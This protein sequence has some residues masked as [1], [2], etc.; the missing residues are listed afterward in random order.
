MTRRDSWVFREG[1]QVMGRLRRGRATLAVG[2]A[3]CA[4]AALPGQAAGAG[5]P[6]P[7]AFADQAV[8]V[9]GATDSTHSVKLSP[10]ST[11]KSSI[12]RGGKLYYQLQLDARETVYVSATVVPGL[13][14]K[15]AY[16]DGVEVSLQDTNGNDCNSSDARFG[17]SQSPRPITAWA[18]RA[19]GPTENRCKAAGTYY[20]VVERNSDPASSTE[21]WDTELRVVS[22][23]AVAKNAPTTPPGSWN[24]AS[25]TPP[26][27]ERK[28]RRGG[29]GFND[30][31]ALRAGTWGDRIKPGQTLFYRVPVDW[32]QQISAGAELGSASGGQ[33]EYVTSAL[34]MSL[35]NPVRGRVDDA[36]T[37]YDGKQKSTALEPLAPV[38][39]ENRFSPVDGVAG[40]RFAGWYYLSVHLNPK[41]ARQFGNGPLDLTLRVNV[42]GAAKSGPAYVG[43]ARPADE[44]S[45]TGQDKEA[46]V[47]GDTAAGNGDG[48]GGGSGDGMKVVAA[49]GF[50]SGAVLLAI[51]G[52]WTLIG[53]RRA[54]ADA[55]S[56]ASTASAARY[57][58]PSAW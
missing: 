24:S 39:Y 38:A 53:R 32:G 18:E 34:V 48:S 40:T 12:A 26:T 7:Y 52:V 58:P 55:A 30:A 42:D 44:F 41:V 2:A 14:S 54:A 13:S 3:L 8:P 9:D 1:W 15:V 28:E 31:R 10:G 11:Y 23:P 6:S 37:V 46:A 45:V 49:G 51:L 5:V 56:A 47:T 43:S 20:A 36:D 4:V 27:G 17:T 21:A 25:P 29:T 16:G 22:E 35:F 33:D 19:I 57:G 50:G